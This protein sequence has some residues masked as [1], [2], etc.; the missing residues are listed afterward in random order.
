MSE[1]KPILDLIQTGM[2]P[3]IGYGV[4]LLWDIR[5]HLTRLNGRIGTCEELRKAHEKSDQDKHDN[6]EERLHD[7]EKALLQSRK[8]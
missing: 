7:V 2:I 5:E 4:K 1:L 6:C 8:A 3:A